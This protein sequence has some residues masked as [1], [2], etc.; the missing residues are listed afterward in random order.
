MKDPKDTTRWKEKIER[1]CLL[2]GLLVTQEIYCR[3]GYELLG[4]V[5]DQGNKKQWPET[6]EIVSE[7][8]QQEELNS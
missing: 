2:N 3:V 8:R 7:V 5:P 1:D 4:S 6:I